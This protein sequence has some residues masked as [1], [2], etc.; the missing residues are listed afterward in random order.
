M[1]QNLEK[2]LAAAVEEV[3]TTMLQC[4]V[5][6]MDSPTQQFRGERLVAGVVGFVGGLNGMIYIYA[7]EQFA[8]RITGRVLGVAPE[9]A[10][11]LEMVNDAMSEL[12]N[13]V[14]GHMKSRL[15]EQGLP[16][17]ETIPWSER[18]RNVTVHSGGGE[19]QCLST[20]RCDG[21]EIVAQVIL[22]STDGRP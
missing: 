11:P 14:A 21:G 8:P 17:Q 5:Q 19:K 7:T 20:V 16:V 1:H 15:D 12:A 3:F 6:A 4:P 18:G 2:L 13:M 10:Q 22:D 9:T